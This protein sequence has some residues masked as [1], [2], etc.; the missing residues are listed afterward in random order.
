MEKQIIKGVILEGV[1]PDELFTRL[2][3]IEVALR[4]LAY[5]IDQLEEP[6][7]FMTRREV[8]D[9]FSVSLP[10]VHEWARRGIVT[11]YRMGNRVFYKRAEVEGAVKPNN[12][13]E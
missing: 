8:A 10:T 3:K 2:E 1:N 13:K 5:K 7:D 12:G 9:L 4:D 6:A 11:S